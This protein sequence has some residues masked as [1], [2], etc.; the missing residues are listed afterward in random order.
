MDVKI[1]EATLFFYVTEQPHMHVGEQMPYVVNTLGNVPYLG[2]TPDTERVVPAS[3][4]NQPRPSAG[5]IH[6]KARPI[7]HENTHN[8]GYPSWLVSP[9]RGVMKFVYTSP[10]QN[11]EC[12]YNHKHSILTVCGIKYDNFVHVHDIVTTVFSM[13]YGRPHLS[14]IR[15]GSE[16]SRTLGYTFA[17]AGG[18]NGLGGED[19]DR[20]YEQE[21]SFRWRENVI[22]RYKAVARARLCVQWDPNVLADVIMNDPEVAQSMAVCES[23]RTLGNK[24]YFSAAIVTSEGCYCRVAITCRNALFTA[25][26][27]KLDSEESAG[28][29]AGVLEKMLDVYTRI[30]PSCVEPHVYPRVSSIEALRHEIPELFVYNYTRECPVLPIMVSQEEAEQICNTQRVILYPLEGDKARYYTAEQGRFVGLKRN[31]LKNRDEFPYLVTCYIQDHMN[32]PSSDTYKY[33]HGRSTSDVLTRSKKGPMPKSI[34]DSRYNRIKV[35]SFAEAVKCAVA[36]DINSYP[37]CPQIARQELW[38]MTDAD[39]MVSV[40][41]GPGSCVYRYFEELVCASIHVVVIKNGN[42]EPLVPRHKGHYVWAPPYQRHVVVFETYK[43]TYGK[44]SCSY[45]FLARG[46]ATMF[47]DADD[48]VSH[49]VAQ[50]SAESVRPP[51]L[52]LESIREHGVLEQVIDRNGKCRTVITGHGVQVDTYMRPLGAPVVPDSVSF[53]DAHIRKM[54]VVKGDLGVPQTDLFKRSTSSVLYFP[55]DASFAHYVGRK[56]VFFAA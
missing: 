43:T 41:N 9:Q 5:Y 37:W 31:R 33:Y 50:K 44:E 10:L 12:S 32:R 56:K 28:V 1:T 54:N 48:V 19:I 14:Y 24:R 3:S 13:I 35:A 18:M 38:D 49:L 52:L 25:M 27:S 16:A 11:V 20:K 15:E 39:I 4:V 53:F 36:V 6:T 26:I 30:A 7:K 21:P 42:M 22:V 8:C 23:N 45:S 29:A 2:A 51:D 55:N 46:G 34:H 47:D 40:A 17:L